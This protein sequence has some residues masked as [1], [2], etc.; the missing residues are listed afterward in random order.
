MTNTTTHTT[1]MTVSNKYSCMEG[2]NVNIMGCRVWFGIQFVD[3]P[4]PFKAFFLSPDNKKT[5]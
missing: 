4:A 3:P 5:I 2:V 1:N